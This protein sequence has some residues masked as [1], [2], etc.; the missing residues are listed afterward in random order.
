L[1]AKHPDGLVQRLPA[2]IRTAVAPAGFVGFR[3][4]DHRFILSSLRLVPGPLTLTSANRSGQSDAVVPEEVVQALGSDVDLVL[5]DGASRYGQPSS[6]VRVIGN[7]LEVLRQG[8]VSEPALRRFASFMVLIVC[9][10]NTCR[11]PMARVLLEKRIA[12]RLGCSVGELEQRGVMVLSAGTSAIEG[13][14]AS[15]EAVQAMRERGLDLTHH[16]SRAVSDVL[17]RFA[18]LILTMTG[19]H[20]DAVLAQWP[21]AAEKTAPLRRDGGDVSDPVGGALQEYTECAN[22]VDAHLEQWI[23]QFDLGSLPSFATA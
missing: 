15:S 21:E 4:P 9:T 7:R 12:D 19:G 6:V 23:D 3:V 14:P 17:V 11:S 8:V 5:S 16:E 13:G 10:G 20:R 1:E 18:D 22:Q 2:A